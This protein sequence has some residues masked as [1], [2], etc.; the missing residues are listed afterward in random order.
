V[1]HRARIAVPIL[2]VL[3]VGTWALLGVLRRGAGRA[4]GVAASGTIEATQVSVASKV[5]GRIQRVHAGEGDEVRSGELLVTVE[6]RELTAQIAQAEAVVAASRARVAQA[7]AAL[8][9]QIRQVDA[10]VAQARAAA[11][12]AR[13]RVSQAGEAQTLTLGQSAQGIK[14]AEAALAAARDSSRAARAARDRTRSDL[15]RAEALFRD[16]AISAQQVDAA[17]TAFAT[18][19]AQYD[20]SA[21]LMA[22][23]EATL[24]LAREN[25]RQVGLR[26]RDVRTAQSQVRQ[27]EAAVALAR[28][29]EEAIAQRRADLAAAEAAVAQAEAGLRVLLTQQENLAITAPLDGVVLV[30][31]ARAGE[32]VA[33][34]AP[35]LTVA[36]L[37]EVW[38]RLYIPLPQLG[39]VALGRP[40][41]VTTDALPGLTFTG[42]VTE[43]SQQAEFTPRNVQTPEERVKLVF[44]VKVTL[45][46]AE[47][48]LKPG[49]P[50]D[51]VIAA[52]AAAP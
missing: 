42:R 6:G 25:E 3:A 43:I 31:H 5:P 37:R 45:P 28:A 36:D 29:G 1:R 2:L 34:G 39:R 38:I 4:D 17:R 49:M 16:G 12:A 30:Q 19:Q 40:A 21:Q 7:R 22:Q 47:R 48:L 33:S 52:A 18:A 20:A 50:A 27:A 32:I 15:T 14:Q 11:D 8:A 51:A 13:E 26:E 23:A 35:I 10:Q 24:R 41:V 9:L 44:A 46:N